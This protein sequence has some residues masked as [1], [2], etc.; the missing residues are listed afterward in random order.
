MYVHIYVYTHTCFSH[1]MSI[2]TCT[3]LQCMRSCY[4]K[5]KTYE[6]FIHKPDPYHIIPV[7]FFSLQC[8]IFPVASEWD[9]VCPGV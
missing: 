5:F 8:R 4:L 2:E 7:V 1:C 9:S 6:I 3:H